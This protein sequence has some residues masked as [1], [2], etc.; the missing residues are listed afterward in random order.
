M[1]GKWVVSTGGPAVLCLYLKQ[2]LETNEKKCSVDK[3]MEFVL[4]M[5]SKK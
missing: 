5:R 3:I 2:Q 4:V 1:N